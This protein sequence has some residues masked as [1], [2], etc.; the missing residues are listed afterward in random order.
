MTRT[1]IPIDRVADQK[2]Y[3][4]GKHKRHGVNVQII[5]DP[6]GRLIWASPALPG[7]AHDLTAAR[8]HDLADALTSAPMMTF[9]DR[10][11]QSAGGSIRTP[12]TRHRRRQRLSRRDKAV[13]LAHA[14][15]RTHPRARRTRHRHPQNLA[16]A[17]QTAL[18]P[19]PRHRNRAGHPGPAPRREPDPQQLKNAQ[20]REA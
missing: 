12:F 7:A 4:C 13:N 18:L 20:L 10:G 16:T 9:A 1:L 6:A 19:T 5:A 15:I 8:T 11:Y 17:Q 14:R 2:P 3:Y